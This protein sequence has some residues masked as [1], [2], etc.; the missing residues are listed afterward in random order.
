[1]FPED[2]MI[3]KPKEQK[4]RKVKAPFIDKLSGLAIVK[5]L[6]GGTHCTLLIKLEFT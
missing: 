6:D 2:H 4:L 3:L 5:V 1:M